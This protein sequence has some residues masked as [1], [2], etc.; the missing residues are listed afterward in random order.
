M[1]RKK[2][3][4]N[5]KK[6]VYI[7]YFSILMAFLLIGLNANESLSKQNDE[8]QSSLKG[9][10]IV[11]DQF[12]TIQSAINAATMG[13]TI[14]VRQ[15]EYRENININKM[16]T[17]IGSGTSGT[18]IT[19]NGASN[20]VTISTDGATIS[21]FTIQNSGS[22]NAG[23]RINSNYN[24]ISRC[25]IKNNDYG[26]Y[27]YASSGNF[28][29]DNIVDD[30]AKSGFLFYR[31]HAN[32]VK[33]NELE[34]NANGMLVNF[35]CLGNIVTGNLFSKNNKTGLQLSET[36]R[37]NTFV[38]NEISKNNAFGIEAIGS[39]ENNIF[40][41]NDM[42]FNGQNALDTSQ[43]YWDA[44]ETIGRG[45]HWSD[46]TGID[47]DGD[48]IGDTPYYIPNKPMLLSQDDENDENEDSYPIM[49]P[50]TPPTLYIEL[51]DEDQV[52][53]N[54]PIDFRISFETLV[55]KLSLD[56]ARDELFYQVNWDDQSAYEENILDDTGVLTNH[57]YTQSGI[58]TVRVR[59]YISLYGHRVYS[60]WFSL[61]IE[62]GALE[63]SGLFLFP[64]VMLE[65]KN[66]GEDLGYQTSLRG[67]GIFN[68]KMVVESNY[69]IYYDD[70]DVD[71]DK[72]STHVDESSFFFI[73]F[74]RI[75]DEY[76]FP[77]AIKCDVTVSLYVSGE[78]I[79]SASI[80]LT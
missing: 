7:T 3:G 13:T 21:G 53:L 62:L 16:I 5:I 48:G 65:Q 59:S 26:M 38:G 6:A 47:S 72:R 15:G 25:H 78:K 77:D 75:V 76:Y 54:T 80:E 57:I 17:I 61:P 60:S 44:G 50:N 10:I 1:F 41:H 63:S 22:N 56:S 29:T 71:I 23:V 66:S 52:F 12:P 64:S 46:Y 55:Q 9:E 34:Q 79:A 40:H 33:G 51:V 30:N 19:G 18:I 74:N 32:E 67:I 31:S 8:I 68:P 11:P 58:Y 20:V 70:D 39:S 49:D 2:Q 42:L 73:W 43:N 45:N 4:R 36:S 27:L 24:S 37:S 35:S 69:W 14:I 28:I